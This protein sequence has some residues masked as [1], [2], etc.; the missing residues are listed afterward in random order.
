MGILS[1][2]VQ[3][4]APREVNKMIILGLNG[5]LHDAS[6]CLIKDGKV[7]GAMEHERL[8]RFKN[9]YL[10]FPFETVHA[11]LTEHGLKQEQI[12]CVVWNFDYRKFHLS[13]L[14]NYI[15]SI[16]GAGDSF[17][18]LRHYLVC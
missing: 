13:G 2:S 17:T 15:R 12:D 16:R 11:L 14:A 1:E 4:R 8:T 3:V 10:L 9:A 6:A 18:V 5:L 7:L